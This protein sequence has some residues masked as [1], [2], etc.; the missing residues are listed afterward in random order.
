MTRKQIGAAFGALIL[1][2]AAPLLTLALLHG[3]GGTAQAQAPPASFTKLNVPDFGQHSQSWCWVGAAA[4]SFWWYAHNTTGQDGLLGGVGHPWETTTDPNSLDP[5]S[6]C[7]YD[8]NDIPQQP[9]PPPPPVVYGYR[10]LLSMIAQTTFKDLNQDGIQQLPA[11]AS[12]CYSDGVEKWDYLIGLRDYVNNYGS[13]LKVHDIIDPA[14]CGAGTGM[15]PTRQLPPTFN[16]RDPCSGAAGAGVPGVDQ[17]VQVPT[18]VDYQ[19]ELSAADHDVLLWMESYYPETAH[20]VTG[21]GYDTVANTITISDPWTRNANPP[22]APHDD[23]WNIADP[24]HNNASGNAPAPYNVCTILN[25]GNPPPN[26]TNFQIRCGATTWTIYDM[27]FVSPLVVNKQVSDVLLDDGSND[28]QPGNELTLL[29]EDPLTRTSEYEYATTDPDFKYLKSTNVKVSVTSLDENLGPDVPEDAYVSFLADVP[30]GCE[31][32]WIPETTP[33]GLHT[34]TLTK[35]DYIADLADPLGQTGGTVIPPG[36]PKYTEKMDGDGN[37]HTIESDLHFQTADWELEEPAGG[38][39]SLLRF[40]EFHCWEAGDFTFTFYNKI[41][42]EP[43]DADVDPNLT[44]NWWKATMVV[45]SLHNADI[46]ILSWSAPSPV[47]GYVDVPFQITADE[48]KHNNGPQAAWSDVTWTAQEPQGGE[49]SARWIAQP[50]DTQPSDEVLDFYVNL[51]EISV[52]LAVSRNLELTCNVAGGPYTVTLIND[53]W[54]VDP[55][56]PHD[57]WEDPIPG[58]NTATFHLSVNC[59]QPA[60]QADVKVLDFWAEPP[61]V[62]I[63]QPFV[64][65][66]PIPVWEVKHNNGPQDTWADVDWWV[67]GDYP[68]NPV[69]VKWMWQQGDICTYQRM[70][71]DCL[72]GNP[73]PGPDQGDIDDLH[74]QVWL[75]VSTDVQLMRGIQF[76]CKD[77]GVFVLTLWNYEYPVEPNVDPD[78]SNNLRSTDVTVYCGVGPYEADKWVMGV[79]TDISASDRNTTD[80]DLDIWTSTNVPITV[81]SLDQNLGP[82]PTDTLITFLA[83]VPAGCEGRWLAQPGDVMHEYEPYNPAYPLDQIHGPSH[84]DAKV[85]GDG[86]PLYPPYRTAESA[87]HFQAWEDPGMPMPYTRSFELHCLAD[88]IYTFTFC[89]KAEVKAPNMDPNPANNWQCQDLTVTSADCSST[90]DSDGDTFKDNIECYLPTDQ[91]DNCPDVIGADDAWPLDIDMT[92]D[93]SVTGDVF[94]Y[95]GR[96]GAT[97]GS[98]M[99]LQRLDLDMDSTLSVT[100]DV[101]MYVGKIGS[102]CT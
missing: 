56:P 93:V 39:L 65:W 72:V 92:K 42:P 78:P 11:E 31:G 45:H 4:N 100:G 57:P 91:S 34:D 69:D 68:Q 29:S 35:A 62:W 77:M 6:A 64:W 13:G 20:V 5:G 96:I 98:P 97:P 79:Y 9:P 10:Q 38:Q 99:W 30:L 15:I 59:T 53:E 46:K 101:F 84:R 48:V 27:I 18:F 86:D 40:F 80:P 58:N 88:G 24:S 83:N 3:V 66:D 89:N 36:D 82:Q 22:V 71:V 44:N 81:T 52:S 85:P 75:P 26:P 102:T 23:T 32:R 70:P 7:W 90:V 74:F 50:G 63:T 95:V 67:T 61:W 76:E 94:F 21:V 43:L 87:L 12:Y 8:A 14:R 47:D 54:P 2:V 73:N 37:P 1:A 41:E 16:Q 19:T 17:V 55:N 49:V 60:G 25:P 28:P 33:D 51:T